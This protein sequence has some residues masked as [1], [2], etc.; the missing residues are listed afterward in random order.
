LVKQGVERALINIKQAKLEELIETLP[1]IEAFVK[2]ID[3]YEHLIPL[4]SNEAELQSLSDLSFCRLMQFFSVCRYSEE[5]P[6]DVLPSLLE[7]MKAVNFSKLTPIGLCNLLQGLNHHR[8]LN[9]GASE[10]RKH[11]NQHP[12]SKLSNELNNLFDSFMEANNTNAFTRN[13]GQIIY[14]LA[15]LRITSIEF[16]VTQVDFMTKH[17]LHSNMSI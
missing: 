7:R 8:H 17:D 9:N 14:H 15:S 5:F 16:F 12:G 10:I 2:D 1:N 13:Y 6:A 3:V 11:F 4:I